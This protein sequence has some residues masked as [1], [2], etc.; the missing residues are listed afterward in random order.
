MQVESNDSSCWFLSMSDTII[1]VDNLSKKY[2]IDHLR[3]TDNGLRHALERAVHAPLNWMRPSLRTEGA[4]HEELWALRDLNLEI[5]Q[6][7][8][9]GI[10][11]RNG[12]GKSP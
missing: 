12:A 5:K 3:A 1:T 2:V 7:D 8:V 6:G 11:G 4:R 10:I 9:V